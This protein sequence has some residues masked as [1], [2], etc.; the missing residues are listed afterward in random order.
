MTVGYYSVL[1]ALKVITL[2]KGELEPKAQTAGSY[3]SFVNMKHVSES[4]S[5]TPWYV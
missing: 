5:M 2:G 3:P 4:H 1:G